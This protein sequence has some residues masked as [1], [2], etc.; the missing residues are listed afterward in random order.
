ME[1]WIFQ[2]KLVIKSSQANVNHLGTKHFLQRN[3]INYFSS[4][5]VSKNFLGGYSF[6]SSSQ[7][8]IK[9]M[10]VWNNAIIFFTENWYLYLI[11]YWSLPSRLVEMP[12]CE[13]LKNLK[14]NVTIPAISSCVTW[15]KYSF[16]SE[17]LQFSVIFRK[18][19]LCQLK[20]LSRQLQRTSITKATWQAQKSRLK[21]CQI[22]AKK[23]QLENC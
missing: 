7:T 9:I 8:I 5:D 13:L 19:C 18:S 2:A 3:I 11:W 1:T 12:R 4:L 23:A 17:E 10:V 6:F 20:D 22:L 15:L 16:K 14:M 21:E